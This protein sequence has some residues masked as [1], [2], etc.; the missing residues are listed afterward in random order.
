[1]NSIFTNNEHKTSIEDN[2]YVVLNFLNVEDINKLKT[3]YNSRIASQQKTGLFESSRHN[4][5]EMNNHINQ[6]IQNIFSPHIQNYFKDYTFY[7]GT[8]MVKST[9]D[10][11]EFPLHQDWNIV[12]EKKY[13]SLFFWAPID[14]TNEENGTI[15]L[16]EG[17]HKFF[18]NYRSGSYKSQM[19]ERKKIPRE[20]IKTIHLEPGQVLIYQ[21]SIFHGSYKNNT[22]EDRIVITAMITDKNAPLYNYNKK[23]ETTAA[24]YKISPT[25]YLN[26]IRIINDSKIPTSAELIDIVPYIH[27]VIDYKKLNNALTGK[28]HG[29]WKEIKTFIQFKIG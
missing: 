4:N 8:F 27:P 24:I 26:D 14:V 18:T 23:D 16:I 11:T 21:P 19:I 12:D 3:L 20:F 15:Y 22:K 25:S 9:K 13:I 5:P 17:S 2:G 28:K 29:V 1:M 7:G 10:S 6:S